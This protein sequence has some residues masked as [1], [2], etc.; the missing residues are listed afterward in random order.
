MDFIIW[1][2]L[3]IPFRIIP[4]KSVSNGFY[5]IKW[6]EELTKFGDEVLNIY[7]NINIFIEWKWIENVYLTNIFKNIQPDLLD[8]ENRL[9]RSFNYFGKIDDLPSNELQNKLDKWLEYLWIVLTYVHAINS[10]FQ[11]WLNILWDTE[12]RK[13]LVVFQNNDEI[14]P[15][16]WFM[17]STWLVTLFKWQVKKFEKTDIYWYE[18]LINNATDF[19][20]P[21][22]EW[23]HLLTTSFWLRDANYYIDPKRSS[24]TI[25]YYLDIINLEIDWIIYLNQNIVLDLLEETWPISFLDW[26]EIITP[27]NFSVFMSSIVEAKLSKQWTLSSPKQILFDFQ[28][29]FINTLLDKWD[30]FAYLKIAIDNIKSRD[31]FIYSFHE[32]ENNLLNILWLTWNRYHS[33]YWSS[34]NFEDDGMICLNWPN[35]I[36]N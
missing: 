5:I 23:I 17:W 12:E 20:L 19:R 21:P 11:A 16:G 34:G 33:L 3:Y 36:M 25:K 1:D 24:E 29:I 9:F 26:K 35:L 6:W 14:R 18:R 2:F 27:D 15:T 7:S 31:L 32:S 28:D 22:P 8:L 13:Y 4:N 30:Y 10:N